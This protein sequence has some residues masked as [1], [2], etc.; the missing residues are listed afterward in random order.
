MLHL[1]KEFGI[2]SSHNSC[3]GVFR[4]QPTFT[5]GKSA[6]VERL[7][8]FILTLVPKEQC[9]VVQ[10]KGGVGMLR[11]QHT[12]PNSEGALVERLGLLVLTLYVVEQCQ[13]VQASG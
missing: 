4:T 2:I 5:N 9:Q 11:T 12:F 10:A 8:L 1:L 3:V 6:L 13:V 7:G